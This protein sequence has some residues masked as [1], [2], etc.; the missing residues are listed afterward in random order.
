MGWLD[1]LRTL[2]TVSQAGL[3]YSKDPFDRERYGQLKQLCAE[4]IAHHSGKSV[5]EA[6]ALLE[7]EKGYPTPKV[8]VRG[9][10]FRSGRVLMV[11]ESSDG[12][13]SLP[14]GWADLGLSPG[15]VAIKEVREE[16]GYEVRATKLLEVV[17]LHP[18]PSLFSVYKLFVRCELLG[19]EPHG[20]VETTA[21]DFFAR[22][23]LPELSERRTRK[24][25]VE[26]V[27]RH[28]DEPERP[29]GF[30]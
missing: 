13:W 18:A 3:A 15:Q 6:S 23:A 2:T 28:L 7:L 11:Q 9:V 14:G 17:G 22:D 24:E 12:R 10:V 5:E 25:H 16:S 19:G 30:D 8:D 26:R 4:I 20:S 27:F 21:V 1:W 29:T